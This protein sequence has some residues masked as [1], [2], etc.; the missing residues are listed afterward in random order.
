MLY[1]DRKGKTQLLSKWSDKWKILL[2]VFF[3]LCVGDSVRILS[4]MVTLH[5]FLTDNKKAALWQ[6]MPI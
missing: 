6:M 4:D 2:A 3:K 5:Q 1:E